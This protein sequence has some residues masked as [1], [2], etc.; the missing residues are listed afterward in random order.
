MSL[1]QQKV[2]NGHLTD[3]VFS[4]AILQMDT[5]VFSKT[6][7]YL[8]LMLKLHVGQGEKHAKAQVVFYCVNMRASDYELGVV[9]GIHILV[10]VLETVISP[11][12]YQECTLMY[13]CEVGV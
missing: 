6:L 9:T 11:C 1:I 12:Y 2:L 3:Y 5:L 4:E 8:F 13:N 10:L 7:Q